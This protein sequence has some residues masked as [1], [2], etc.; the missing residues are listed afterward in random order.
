MERVFR[1][2]SLLCCIP[3]PL[4]LIFQTHLE[5][6][7]SPICIDNSISTNGPL[8]GPYL[9]VDQDHATVLVHPP[10]VDIRG[11]HWCYKYIA[12]HLEENTFS[13]YFPTNYEY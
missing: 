1:T 8:L 12:V 6:N 3:S 5:R 7:V 2:Q 11:Q 4:E 13:S 10:T 9:R